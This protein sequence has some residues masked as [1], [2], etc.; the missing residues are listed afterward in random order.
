MNFIIHANETVVLFFYFLKEIF[1][2]VKL[3]PDLQQDILVKRKVKKFCLF[4]FFFSPLYQLQKKRPC[5]WMQKEELQVCYFKCSLSCSHQNLSCQY[6]GCKRIA[7]ELKAFFFD[8]LYQWMAILDC[9]HFS[10]FRDFLYL[11]SFTGQVFVYFLCNW[12]MPLRFYIN[13]N[14]LLKSTYH[15]SI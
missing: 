1:N 3:K 12:V 7:V 13:F 4:F 11:F 14:Y 15:A 8:N 9:F 2:Y 6:L 5:R 10:S